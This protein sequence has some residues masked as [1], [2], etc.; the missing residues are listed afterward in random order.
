[1]TLGLNQ[2]GTKQKHTYQYIHI[3]IYIYIYIYI[4]II[5][6]PK[7]MFSVVNIFSSLEKAR[8]YGTAALQDCQIQA[9]KP[10]R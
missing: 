8:R 4:K 9:L 5:M 3:Y 7:A 2:E 6:D 10:P 1:M